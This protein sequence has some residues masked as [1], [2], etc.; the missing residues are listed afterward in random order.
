MNVTTPGLELKVSGRKGPPHN[1][2][3][4]FNDDLPESNLNGEDCGLNGRH[5]LFCHGLTMST[6]LS[7]T[8]RHPCTCPYNGRPAC[9]IV[10]N[11]SPFAFL[12][13]ALENQI[14]A[15]QISFIANNHRKDD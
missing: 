8:L 10:T 12:R 15:N 6:P 1:E 2:P 5:N 4:V 13:E 11:R 3:K 14:V 9:L 7:W